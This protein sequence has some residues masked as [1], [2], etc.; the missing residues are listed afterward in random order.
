MPGPKKILLF[1]TD[2]DR[3]C[4]SAVDLLSSHYV[5][6]YWTLDQLKN[7]L[8]LVTPDLLLVR[9][10]PNMRPDDRELTGVIDLLLTLRIP[11]VI[12]IAEP[13][14]RTV[15]QHWHRLPHG[16]RVRSL[17]EFR[18]YLLEGNYIERAEPAALLA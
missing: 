10:R 5:R 2:T 13:L 18:T 6:T 4:K 8:K 11:F 1:N 7:A 16:Y 12:S 17:E 3:A 14:F 9:I 15:E